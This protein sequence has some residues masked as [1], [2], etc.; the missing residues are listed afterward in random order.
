MYFEFFKNKAT[1]SIQEVEWW[2]LKYSDTFKKDKENADF[3]E[4]YSQLDELTEY[5]KL[6]N[7]AKEQLNEFKRIKGCQEKIKQWLIK[8]EK[9]ASQNLACLL[10]DYLDYSVNEKDNV[11]L[12]TYRNGKEEIEIFVD[13]QDF[14]NLIEFKELFDELYYVK[15]LYPKGLKKIDEEMKKLPPT[16]AINNWDESDKTKL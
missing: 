11:N 15:K 5:H 10:T 7:Y 14:R 12:L 6:E 4:L 1:F 9:I 2:L 13:R 8:N 16:M 3:Y